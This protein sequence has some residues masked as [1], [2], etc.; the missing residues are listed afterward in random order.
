[1]SEA[2]YL[3]ILDW[4]V[5]NTV[6]GKPASIAEARSLKTRRKFYCSRV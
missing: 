2:D 6:A 4:L 3:T 5:R 1:M